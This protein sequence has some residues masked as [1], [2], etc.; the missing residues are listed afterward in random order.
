MIQPALEF[1]RQHAQAID[2][3]RL[4]AQH[5]GAE[6]D[7]TAPGALGEGDL[8]RGEVSLRADE[9]QRTLWLA[10]VFLQV[11][12]QVSR[13]VLERGDQHQVERS[14]PVR[15]E[16]FLGRLRG[17][18]GRQPVLAALLGGLDDRRLPLGLFGDGA[19]VVLDLGDG[20]FREQ[21]G[22]PSRAEFGGLL[23][24]EVHVFSFGN[25]LREREAAGQ[26][27]RLGAVHDRQADGPPGGIRGNGR[28]G[29]GAL[30]VEDDDLLA[31]L[32]AQ[33][34]ER[35]VRLAFVEREGVGVP[36]GGRDVEAMHN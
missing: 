18:D 30:A 33:D 5:D 26:R 15:G 6:R 20:A 21:R 23:D 8:R 27:R 9:D 25:G 17:G 7:R 31:G 35:V 24:D 2:R 28:G 29:F 4:G 19:L 36:G 14:R 11:R 1:V 22:D 32:E 12:A 13:I 34:V 3:R 10:A 16:K